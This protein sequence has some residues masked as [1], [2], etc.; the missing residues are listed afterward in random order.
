MTQKPPDVI[1]I[2]PV[3]RRINRQRKIPAAQTPALITQ[4]LPGLL[5]HQN[6]PNSITKTSAFSQFSYFNFQ[7]QPLSRIY[8]EQIALGLIFPAKL[9]CSKT[10]ITP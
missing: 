6:T 5:R 3:L 4:H 8:T 7:K 1:I 10:N 9:Y 2:V